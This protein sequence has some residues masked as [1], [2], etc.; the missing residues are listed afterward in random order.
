MENLLKKKVSRKEFLKI[1]GVLALTGI[2]S[3][4]NLNLLKSKTK[5]EGYG[6]GKYGQA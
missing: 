1:C 4:S 5:K 6:S 2:F 3:L